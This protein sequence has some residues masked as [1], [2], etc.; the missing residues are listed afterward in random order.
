VQAWTAYDGANA[1]ADFDAAGSPTARYLHA[2]GVDEL[3]ART[4]AADGRTLWYLKDVRGSTRLLADLALPALLD[5][6]DAIAYDAYGNV[7][8]E[9]APALGGRFKYTGREYDAAT[10]LY[11]YRNRWYDPRA[12]VFVE[13]DPLGFA[14]GDA[15]LSRYVGNAPTIY[16]DPLGL[17]EVRLHEAEFGGRG[18][19]GE[20]G[21]CDCDAVAEL[22]KV[23]RRRF[24]DARVKAAYE[25][26]SRGWMSGDSTD[27]DQADLLA[28]FG[29][30]Y[31]TEGQALLGAAGWI[32]LD[33]YVDPMRERWGLGDL[34]FGSAEPKTLREAAEDLHKRLQGQVGANKRLFDPFPGLFKALDLS[35]RQLAFIAEHPELFDDAIK[36]SFCRASDQQKAIL[37]HLINGAYDTSAE[38]LRDAAVGLGMRGVTAALGVVGKLRRATDLHHTIPTE[39][40]KKLP[41]ALRNHPDIRGRAGLP[42]RVP[43]DSWRHQNEIHDKRGI[44]IGGTGIRGGRYSLRFLCPRVF[45]DTPLRSNDLE[46]SVP[47][48]PAPP[49]RI[50]PPSA[51]ASRRRARPTPS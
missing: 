9:T 38:A 18:P 47:S 6:V 44:S 7:L 1:Y 46:R 48:W 20:F 14:A 50:V 35:G 45:L 32:G 29:E 31:G 43:V 26:F 11:D 37:N 49:P 19:G 30:L 40:R 25:E 41:P 8:S 36:A 2:L 12:G 27:W 39:I 4:D 24:E 28:H 51:A 21:H 5:L 13:Q 22:G 3:L 23:L 34:R 33:T 10:G 17:K 42:N 16:V 15:N